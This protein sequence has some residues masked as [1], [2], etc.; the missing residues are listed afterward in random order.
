MKKILPL[1]LALVVTLGGLHAS[2]VEELKKG[3]T[4]S[5]ATKEARNKRRFVDAT[6]VEATQTSITVRDAR[7][8]AKILLIDLPGEIVARLPQAP[9]KE[10]LY[11]EIDS[12]AS[13]GTQCG[14]SVHY[15]RGDLFWAFKATSTNDAKARVLIFNSKET[16]RAVPARFFQIAS[17]LDNKT[18][19]AFSADL[20][21]GFKLH[22][23]EGGQPR[24][25]NSA[26]ES[27]SQIEAMTMAE[28]AKQAD[29]M[30]AELAVKYGSAEK[31]SRQVK[32]D[33]VD[34]AP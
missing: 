22:Q 24:L 5:F 11:V 12:R 34:A 2:T 14:L 8:M 23:T 18:R 20:F 32:K 33:L 17:S 4:V 15:N 10:S 31:L 25:V 3:D 27:I 21:E 29:K 7:G 6:V 9:L 30:F 26:G 1:L 16:L 19:A 13:D 28:L